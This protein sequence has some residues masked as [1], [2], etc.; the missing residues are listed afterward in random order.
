MATGSVDNMGADDGPLGQLERS[1]IEAF[2]RGR[3]YD[4]DDLAALAEADRHALLKSASVYASSKL[5]EVESRARFVH[6]IHGDGVHD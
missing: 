1:L 2:V 6:E 3:G 5:S 4:P